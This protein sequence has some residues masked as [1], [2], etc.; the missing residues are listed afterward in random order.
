M[1]QVQGKENSR[2]ESVEIAISKLLRIGVVLA[3]LVIF[4]GLVQLLITGDSGYPEDTYPTGFGA[5]WS[6]LLEW[7]SV[8]VIETGL[9]LLILTPIF[10][11]VVSLV[12]FLQE[13]DYKFVAISSIV[14]VIL[15]IS[16]VIGKAG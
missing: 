16:F 14:L 4:A 5:I 8:A 1:N 10:R 3:A 15:I 13:K 11:V 12:T 7:K 9:L 6:G 2:I